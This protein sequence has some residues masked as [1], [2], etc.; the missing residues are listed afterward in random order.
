MFTKKNFTEKLSSLESHATASGKDAQLLSDLLSPLKVAINNY[1]G[2]DIAP[3]VSICIAALTHAQVRTG[4]TYVDGSTVA[5]DVGN[6]PTGY[7]DIRE[8]FN[9]GIEML[10]TSNEVFTSSI[11]EVTPT[12]EN[13]TTGTMYYE[14]SLVTSWISQFSVAGTYLLEDLSKISTYANGVGLGY[15]VKNIL[16]P[17]EI[18]TIPSLVD[19]ARNI[20]FNRNYLE[21][22]TVWELDIYIPSNC[23]KEG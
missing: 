17:S 20:Y 9:V 11:V 4:I 7:N 6:E 1:Y 22:I 3:S 16:E 19:I 5:S 23:R 12:L 15:L 14:S 2:V 10:D 18:A 8:L 21:L 13:G